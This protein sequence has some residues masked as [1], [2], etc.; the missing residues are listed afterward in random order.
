VTQFVNAAEVWKK[1]I[2]EYQPDA[3][4]LTGLDQQLMNARI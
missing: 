1:R 2:A 3:P 4:G